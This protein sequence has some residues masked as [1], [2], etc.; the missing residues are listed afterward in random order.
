[1]TR[2]KS[3]NFFGYGWAVWLL[4]LVTLWHAAPL[5]LRYTTM[6][7][8]N[9]EAA[10]EQFEQGF[11]LKYVVLP[12][13]AL[14]AGVLLWK[15]PELRRKLHVKNALAVAL[16]IHLG[17]AVASVV[18]SE[19]P[20][21]TLRRTMVLL[22]LCV[23]T[24]AIAVL[25]DSHQIVMLG[26]TLCAAI[27]ALSVG[28]E[29]ALGT[30]RPWE[31]GYRFAG[32]THYNRQG[33]NCAVL[34]LSAYCLSTYAQKSRLWLSMT[35]VA[36]AFLYLTRSR[37]ALASTLLALGFFWFVRANPRLKMASVLFAGALLSALLLVMPDLADTAGKAIL[38]GRDDSDVGTLTNRVPL[39]E[40]CI[41]YLRERPLLGFGYDSFWTAE[42]IYAISS[43][44]EWFQWITHSHNGYI[45][46]AL[47]IGLVGVGSFVVVLLLGIYTAL[48][49]FFRAARTEH[50]YSACLLLWLSL[51]MLLEG[52]YF[53]PFMPLVM[54]FAA[55]AR[56]AFVHDSPLRPN[57]SST[58]YFANTYDAERYA[59][60]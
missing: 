46:L 60:V 13:L 8:F 12:V 57:E 2:T 3:V 32:V 16:L 31:A 11:S 4:I 45:E 28:A 15:R 10:A 25:C 56:L 26:A 22:L 5:H 47:G 42:R 53:Q 7:F 30:F 40:E 37:T 58:R 14:W 6:D 49:S 48:A 35:G 54:C 55:L 27:L 19:D 17:I 44:Q 23:A 34:A 38:L 36:L 43:H 29:V 1:M 39:W 52:I 51:N 41:E 50:L 21:F 24:L 9:G 59:S 18:W 20:L 33:I